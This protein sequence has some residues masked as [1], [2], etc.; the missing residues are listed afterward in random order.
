MGSLREGPQRVRIALPEEL[1]AKAIEALNGIFRNGTARSWQEASADAKT[2][3]DVGIAGLY[4]T[5]LWREQAKGFSSSTPSSLYTSE[6]LTEFFSTLRSVGFRWGFWD[7][8][9]AGMNKG[10][11]LEWDL[12]REVALIPG[13]DW[14]KGPEHIARLVEEIEARFRV[15][16]A[17]GEAEALLE[18]QLT[19]TLPASIGHNRPPESIFDTGISRAEFEELK[20]AVGVLKSQSQESRA[21]VAAVATAAEVADGVLRKI[22]E[23]LAIKAGMDFDAFRKGFW[24]AAGA[25]MFIFVSGGLTPLLQ[26]LRSLLASVEVWLPLLSEVLTVAARI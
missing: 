13:G 11:P 12:Q 10:T 9:Y 5:P 14:Q 18:D 20:A 15:R 1:V 21:D 23:S 2:I 26:S 25:G 4:A 7:R 17:A 3:D 24:G 6:T 19:R 22:L 16:T 8:W